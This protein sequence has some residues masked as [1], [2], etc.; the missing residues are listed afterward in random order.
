VEHRPWTKEGEEVK[1][2]LIEPKSTKHTVMHHAARTK[3]TPRIGTFAC[4]TFHRDTKAS[5]RANLC[6]PRHD[7]LSQNN[8]YLIDKLKYCAHEK[9]ILDLYK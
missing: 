9:E 2:M 6:H 1:V 3:W 7:V 4:R 5:K 8:I